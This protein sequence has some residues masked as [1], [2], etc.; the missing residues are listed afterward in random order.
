MPYRCGSYHI[1]EKTA[2]SAGVYS[3]MILCPEVAAEARPGQFVHIKVE[4]F[5]LRRPISIC[6]ID[7]KNGWVRI[8]FEIRGHG[9]AKLTDANVGDSIDMIAP[10]G[11]GFTIPEDITPS[12]RIVTVGGGIGIPPL[13]GVAKVFREKSTAILGFR[14]YD[15]VILAN[16][17]KQNDARVITCT[18]DGS[19]GFKGSVILPFESELAQNDVD[20]V[21]AC[22]P[23]PMLAAIIEICKKARINCEVSLE[24]RMG[25]GV[26]A[27][28]VCACEIA[29]QN[30][31]DASGSCNNM[32]MVCKDGPVFKGEEVVL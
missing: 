17:F 3:Y 27:C 5:T 13:L 22:G 2:I 23:E 20:M 1:I 16:D 18:D 6:D 7:R 12:R 24:Q 31:T 29:R 21:Y 8:V 14:S 32:L 30:G 4:G 26:G 10:L 15:K 11:N 9:T 25:C 19:V 28:A